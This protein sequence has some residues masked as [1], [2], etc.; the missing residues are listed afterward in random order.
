MDPRSTLELRNLPDR[1]AD[2]LVGMI[3][4]GEPYTPRRSDSV[5]G[6]GNA[7][8]Y[9]ARKVFFDGRFLQSRFYSRDKL[10]AGDVIRGPAMITEY[11]AATVL[12]PG[13]E[14]RV[15]GFGNLLI[16]I[17]NEEFK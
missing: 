15:D 5:P 9:A 4:K 8:C 13:D 11:T 6:E 16:S 10:V 14:M 3:A 12:P 2:H 1:L 17:A 7:A